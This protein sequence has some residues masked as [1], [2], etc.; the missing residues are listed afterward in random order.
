MKKKIIYIFISVIASC[1]LF[2]NQEYSKHLE[3]VTGYCKNILV[4]K[5]D[6]AK[7]Y[8]NVI[9]GNKQGL[10]RIFNIDNSIIDSFTVDVKTQSYENNICV[11]ARGLGY[12]NATSYSTNKLAAGVYFLEKKIPF[13]ISDTFKKSDITII[14]PFL[15]MQTENNFGG[16]S[17]FPYNSNN[18]VS[19]DE[20]SFERPAI[21]DSSIVKFTQWILNNFKQYRIKIITEIELE[22]VNQLQT[23]LLIIYGNSSFWTLKARK[24][25]DAFLK[26]GGNVLAISTYIMNNRFEYSSKKSMLFRNKL[27]EHRYPESPSI[28]SYWNDRN[29]KYPNY[30]SIGATYEI[31]K[32]TVE[33]NSLKARFVIKEPVHEIFKGISDSIEFPT[34]VSNAIQYDIHPVNNQPVSIDTFGQFQSKKILAY[35]YRKYYSLKTLSGF[36]EFQKTN[37]SGKILLLG[38]SELTNQKYLKIKP[39]EQVIKNSINYL[40]K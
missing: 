23:K 3:I 4:Q 15:N 12:K 14:F 20:I 27:S 21:I 29:N 24:N 2:L 8:M 28:K 26:S 16:K 19:S 32:N 40:L 6:S 30:E 37:T 11:Y 5:G 22:D 35:T 36:F 31:G 33:F 39:N 13:I 1:L 17:L 7:F 25:F 10:L 38:N 34:T 9:E 18:E